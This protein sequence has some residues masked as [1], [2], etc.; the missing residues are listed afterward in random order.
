MFDAFARRTSDTI[1]AGESDHVRSRRG[2]RAFGRSEGRG[3]IP[4]ACRLRKKSCVG[5]GGFDLV[6]DAKGGVGRGASGPAAI[7]GQSGQWTPTPTALP[8]PEARLRR[9][10]LAP[11]ARDYGRG[12]GPPG[13][14][15]QTT[16]C[17]DGISSPSTW[18]RAK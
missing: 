15:A 2:L 8:Q 11:D 16:R 7:G 1:R 14:G 9:A 5:G 3:D 6:A 12:I 17:A 18:S 13:P 4:L 10:R